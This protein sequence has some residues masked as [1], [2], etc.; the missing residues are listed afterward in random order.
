[1]KLQIAEQQ[2]H[3]CWRRRDLMWCCFD[4]SW[5]IRTK[6]LQMN[7]TYQTKTGRSRAAVVCINM[8]Y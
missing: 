5:L 8:A 4:C 6:L 3:A 2:P 1:M 7:Q